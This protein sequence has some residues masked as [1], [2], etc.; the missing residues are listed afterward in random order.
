MSL[1]LA[2]DFFNTLDTHED[3][4]VIARELHARGDQIHIVS[5]ISPGLP[6]DNDDAYAGMLKRLKVP[7]TAIHR[8]D[9]K[10]ELKLEVLKRIGAYGFWDDVKENVELARANSILTCH[11]GVDASDWLHYET[12][13]GLVCWTVRR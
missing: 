12:K 3:V 11:V 4:R 9:H 8:V 2:F 7:F 6:M 5:A 13:I 1:V 10:P